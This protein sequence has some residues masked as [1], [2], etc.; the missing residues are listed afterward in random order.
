MREIGIDCRLPFYQRGGISQY[1]LQLIKAIGRQKTSDHFSLFQMRKDPDNLAAAAGNPPF[2]RV[3][4]LTP[5]HHR[6]EPWALGLE[7]MAHRPPVDLFHSPDFIPPRL[8]GVKR[9]ITVHDLNFWFFPEF[10]TAGS[11]RYYRDQIEWAVSTA[12]HISADSEQTRQDLIEQL[13]V[14]PER[15]TTVYLAVDDLYRR[16]YEAAEIAA[17]LEKYRLQ[18]G[19]ILVVGTLE[20]RKNLPML[21]EAYHRARK[22]EGLAVPLV[23]V[24][25]RGWLDEEI[26]AA[27]P[28]LELQSAVHHLPQVTNLE[29]AHLYQAAGLLATP[30]HYEGFGLPALEAI[31]GGCPV[32]VSDRGSLPE[33][34]GDAGLILPP[35]EPQAWAEALVRVLVDKSLREKMVAAGRRHAARFSWEKAAAQTLAIY[36]Q[37]LDTPTP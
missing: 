35:D 16:T 31:T 14:P 8:R 33:I 19:F 7:I 12:D 22:K 10:L 25:R 4:V 6:L 30:S 20:P 28:R 29:L 34:A 1:I 27:I 15:V 3:D 32:V 2:S 9:V 13:A 37:L 24:G 36:D 18:A 17:T 11:R 21:F 23:L 26:F 5:C